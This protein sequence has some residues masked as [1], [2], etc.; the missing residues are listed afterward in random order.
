MLP[1]LLPTYIIYSFYVWLG[2]SVENPTKEMDF[3]G[4]VDRQMEMVCYIYLGNIPPFKRPSL[5][6]FSF[7]QKEN[8]EENKE[9]K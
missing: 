7:F 4:G 5:C 1:C 9:E 2:S 6:C 3:E 8:R